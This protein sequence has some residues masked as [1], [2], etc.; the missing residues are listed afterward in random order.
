MSPEENTFCER[1]FI[2]VASVPVE[3]ILVLG[4]DFNGYVG[5]H[6][7]GFE[8]VR[9]G[10]GYGMRNQ[11]GFHILDFC[12][13]NKLAITNT[14]FHKNKAGLLLPHL[15]VIIHRLTSSLLGE[16]K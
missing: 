11:N 6:S 8:G 15:E 5:D 3:E 14:F 7:A 10:S 16:H 12:V 13:A 4:S 9:G 1:V 2:V